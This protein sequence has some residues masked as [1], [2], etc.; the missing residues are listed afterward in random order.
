MQTATIGAFEP[1]SP[2]LNQLPSVVGSVANPL[3]DS[4]VRLG[5]LVEQLV[6]Q[7][8]EQKRELKRTRVALRRY[9]RRYMFLRRRSPVAKR[10][11]KGG[12]KGLKRPFTTVRSSR[13]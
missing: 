10:G 1:Q 13:R 9:V 5:A 4:V 12:T 6:E 3:V 2:W 7:L 8:E 11:T